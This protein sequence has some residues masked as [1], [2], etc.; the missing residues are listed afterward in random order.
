ML[1]RSGTHFLFG[2]L[3]RHPD[4][5][6]R[7]PYED[8]LLGHVELLDAY[9][10]SVCPPWGK[11]IPPGLLGHIGD[12]IVSWLAGGMEGMR[13]VAKFPGLANAARAH[14]LFPEARVLLL[15]RDGRS[16]VESAV[17]SWGATYA[18]ETFKWRAAARQ[19]I[20][21]RERLGDRVRIVRYEDLLTGLAEE[22]RAVLHFCELDPERYDFASAQALPLYGSSTTLG[23]QPWVHHTPVE[24]PADFGGLARWE[25]WD[26]RRHSRFDAAAGEE[27]EALGYT[28]ASR[29]APR[30][31]RLFAAVYGLWFAALERPRARRLA[32]LR[33]FRSIGWRLRQRRKAVALARVS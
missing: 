20:V 30:G 24:R 16:V 28:R 5:V 7:E 19:A 33:P 9:A 11:R 10:A 23:G 17:R 21:L 18:Y 31:A 13:V 4:V 6:E 15:I 1:Q 27:L 26:E 8:D 29:R 25:T 3:Q 12:G 2:L 22:M 14:D 32:A